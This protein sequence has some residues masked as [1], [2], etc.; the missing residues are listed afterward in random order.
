MRA[1]CENL[2]MKL[3]PAIGLAA[4]LTVAACDEQP[5][6]VF[7]ERGVDRPGGDLTRVLMEEDDPAFCATACI[8]HEQCQ[9]FTLVPRGVQDSKPVC[10]LK[11]GRPPPR[12]NPC[13]VSGVIPGR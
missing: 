13:C 7:A 5:T 2:S 3:R 10:Y 9:A 4:A 8:E 12:N 11:S 1:G 6:L